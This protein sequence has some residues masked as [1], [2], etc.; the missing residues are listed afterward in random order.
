MVHVL[1]LLE[2]ALESTSLAYYAAILAWGL[3]TTMRLGLP[4][5]SRLL[6]D[7]IPGLTVFAAVGVYGYG[8]ARSVL[9]YT[10]FVAFWLRGQRMRLGL[11]VLAA[12]F[13]AV[14]SFVLVLIVTLDVNE[15]A[16]YALA[17]LGLSFTLAREAL[18]LLWRYWYWN[19]ERRRARRACLLFLNLLC[20]LALVA[21]SVTFF[22]FSTLNRHDA[23]EN[24][25]CNVEYWA[26][27]FVLLLPIYQIADAGEAM[28]L[29]LSKPFAA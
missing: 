9:T 21:L 24:T 18:L 3:L 6:A 10:I 13:A 27:G 29:L 20:I 25:R 5:V 26:L 1:L 2:T 8:V 7:D 28:L 23:T 4:S 17:G 14:L 15:T 12:G 22:V 11:A 19:A 16:H